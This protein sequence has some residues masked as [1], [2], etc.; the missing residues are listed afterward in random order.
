MD[1]LQALMNIYENKEHYLRTKLQETKLE[2]FKTEIEATAIQDI[3]ITITK[4][5]FERLHQENNNNKK[6]VKK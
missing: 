3:S 2:Y 1:D 5:F 6:G 4:I